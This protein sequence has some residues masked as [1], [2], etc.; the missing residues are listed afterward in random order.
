MPKYK[1][2]KPT[3]DRHGIAYHTG[4]NIEE[5]KKIDQSFVSPRDRQVGGN[6]YASHKH[7]PFDIADEWNLSRRLTV[8]L[9]YILR[10]KDDKIED[11]EKCKHCIDLEIERLQN[12]S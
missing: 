10:E 9:K 8:A 12:E 5:L 11:L 3:L 7:Q 2:A 1:F 4:D 6:H